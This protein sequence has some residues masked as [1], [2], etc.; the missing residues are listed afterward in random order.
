[1]PHVLHHF[2]TQKRSENRA[3]FCPA[4]RAHLP[5]ATGERQQPFRATPVAFKPGKTKFR[6]SAVQVPGH[7]LVRQTAPETELRLEALLPLSAK[8]VVQGL[9]EFP[10]GSALRISR[11]VEANDFHRPGTRRISSQG[12]IETVEGRQAVFLAGVR[13][14]RPDR[15]ALGNL[16]TTFDSVTKNGTSRIR[17]ALGFGPRERPRILNLRQR[18]RPQ[19]RS[20]RPEARSRAWMASEN[21]RLLGNDA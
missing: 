7:R 13:L 17:Q 20:P 8:A 6:K 18:K 11:T 5:R 2:L 9:R 3:T 12:R 15:G 4:R 16:S 10:E 21:V 1:M 19:H 14:A